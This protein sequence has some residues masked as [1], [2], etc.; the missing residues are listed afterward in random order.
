MIWL[1]FLLFLNLFLYLRFNKS[2]NLSNKICFFKEFK[3]LSE[4]HII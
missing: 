4:I 1:S 3:E 2:I